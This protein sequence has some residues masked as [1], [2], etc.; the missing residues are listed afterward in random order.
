MTAKFFLYYNADDKIDVHKEM[1]DL[2]KILSEYDREKV[3]HK[4]DRFAMGE[5]EPWSSFEMVGCFYFTSIDI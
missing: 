5:I 1:R 3:W 2:N 4:T